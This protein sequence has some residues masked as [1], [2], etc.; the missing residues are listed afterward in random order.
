VACAISES[1][2]WNSG[3][4]VN[5]WASFAIIPSNFGEMHSNICFKYTNIYEN[6]YLLSQEESFMLALFISLMEEEDEF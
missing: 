5:K 2:G 1:A 4:T 3:L 6:P